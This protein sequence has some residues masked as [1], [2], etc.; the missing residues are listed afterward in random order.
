MDNGFTT[1]D[2]L[3]ALLNDN[4][5]AA[6]WAPGWGD[7]VGI[8][9]GF[10]DGV[11]NVV[12]AGAGL[13]LA[14]SELSVDFDGPGEADTAARSDAVE[15]MAAEIEDLQDQLTAVTAALEGSQRLFRHAVWDDYDGWGGWAMGN[16]TEMFGGVNPSNWGNSGYYAWNMSNQAGQMRTLFNQK[17]WPGPN[18]MVHNE[19]YT[20]AY[21]WGSSN[22]SRWAA[23]LMRIRNN[24]GSSISIPGSGLCFYFSAY[25]GWGNYASL[26]LNGAS[27]WSYTSSTPQSTACVGLNIPARRTSTV[28]VMSSSYHYTNSYNWGAHNLTLGF[29]NNS[30]TLPVGLQFVDDLDQMADGTNI[31]AE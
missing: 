18:A 11:D 15:T 10:A 27:T 17:L 24:T 21:G 5:R 3:T 12:T 20:T 13:S 25:G 30:L 22:Y 4:Y 1:E 7:I 6:G 28:V 23:V 8:P 31:W 9:A 14:G 29:Y 2:E 26:S 16:R 19:Q